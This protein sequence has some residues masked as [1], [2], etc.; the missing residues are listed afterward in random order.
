MHALHLIDMKKMPALFVGHGSPMTATLDNDFTRALG[1]LGSSLP[2]PKAILCISAHWLTE[3]T[4]I[5]AMERPRTIHDFYGFP[6]EL[7][8]LQY[9]AP[10]SPQLARRIR[11]LLGKN[12]ASLDL[13]WG[14]DHGTWSV[15]LHIFPKADIP[16]LQL[17]IDYYKPPEFHYALGHALSPLRD[18]GVLVMGSGNIAHNLRMVNFGDMNAPA[19][20]WAIDFDLAVKKCMDAHDHK[21]LLDYPSLPSAQFAVP[22]PDHY[23]SL[24]YALGMQEKGE[25]VSYPYEG[26]QHGTL[27]MRAVKIG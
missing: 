14:L 25:R 9:N 16:V 11:E 15:L 1:R 5:T 2:K 23:Y 17:S 24:L 6:P 22:T 26:F 19:E 12:A 10:G 3:G 4:G 7:Y 8:K 21:P 18:E 20:Q 27:S 13:E